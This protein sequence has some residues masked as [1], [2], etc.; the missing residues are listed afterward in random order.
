MSKYQVNSVNDILNIA[1]ENNMPLEQMRFFIGVD[2][3]EPRAFGIY[4]DPVTNEW[5]VY[6]NKDDGTR[7]ER[8]RGFDESYAANEIWAKMKD[9]IGIRQMEYNGAMGPGGTH[10]TLSPEHK[11]AMAAGRKK[12]KNR[13]TILGGAVFA[14]IIGLAIIGTVS[15]SRGHKRHN[16]YYRH[17]NETYYSQDGYWYYFDDVIDSWE[18]YYDYDDSWYD[19]EY[20]YGDYYDFGDESFY[21]SNS[22]YYDS[23][24]GEYYYDDSG[25]DDD[26]DWSWGS[27]DSW[28]SDSDWGDWSSGDTDWSSDW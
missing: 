2:Y 15:N 7:A 25:S 27:D 9:E 17:N 13:D 12:K 26:D 6:K 5:V 21:F 19:D 24:A 28:D 14:G 18:P 16:G 10:R 22:D 11:A 1:A 4:Q 8:Y 20:Y 23:S 3:R